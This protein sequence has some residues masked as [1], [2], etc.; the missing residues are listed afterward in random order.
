MNFKEQRL[1]EASFFSRKREKK[2]NRN[3]RN[4]EYIQE[5]GL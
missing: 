5:L 1:S 4:E 3:Y 2:T